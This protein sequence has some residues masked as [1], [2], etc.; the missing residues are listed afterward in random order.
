MSQNNRKALLTLPV[1][2]V[3]SLVVDDGLRRSVHTFRVENGEEYPVHLNKKTLRVFKRRGVGCVKCGL[4]GTHFKVGETVSGHYSLFLY[5]TDKGGEEVLMT[6]DHI[7]PK[8]WGGPDVMENLQPM[9]EH[10][11]IEKSATLPEQVVV[12]AETWEEFR[13]NCAHHDVYKSLHVCV[14]GAEPQVCTRMNCHRIRPKE[15]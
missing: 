6:K 3:M 4:V 8:S 2:E 15:F 12:A 5:G 11:N 9:C 10:C 1:Q 7:I 14:Y 13:T